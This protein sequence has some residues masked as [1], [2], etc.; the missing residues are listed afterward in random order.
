MFADAKDSGFFLFMLK[1]KVLVGM[2][3][4]IDSTVAAL[5][6]KKKGFDV[7]GIFML[8][9]NSEGLKENIC[10]SGK[11]LR[12]L[13]KVCYKY[14]IPLKV[15]DIKNKFQQT[16]VNDFIAKYEA[17]L[18]P[19]PCVLCNEKIKFS[20]LLKEAKKLNIDFISTG[21]YVTKIKCPDFIWRNFEKRS[22]YQELIFCLS[23]AKD[24]KKD[25]S[26]FLYRLSQAQ[27]QKSLFPL[28][29]YLKSEVRKIANDLKIPSAN[30]KE[31]QD[32]CFVHGNDVKKFLEA[33]A[34]KKSKG[35]KIIDASGKELGFHDGLLH[36]TIGQRKGIKIGGSGPY[37]VV[38]RDFEK[39]QMTV[40][41]DP[42]DLKLFSKKIKLSNVNW[43][44]GMKPKLPFR[45]NAQVRYKTKIVPAVVFKLGNKYILTFEKYEK[46]AAPGQS[47]VFY[48]D[49]IVIG[50][51]IIDEVCQP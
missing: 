44:M 4:G 16:I 39:N 45:I 5:L 7:I 22:S 27:V 46:I 47:A 24:K 51:G 37:F 50:G 42:N 25:Q 23:V 33:N 13:Q 48:L 49:D 12:D 28:G 3:G 14:D 26:Y 1:R 30:K 41:K 35:G 19:N 32:V 21:H 34:I 40:S 31:S 10:C 36:F 8:F 43:Q 18:T 29:N 6:L 17:G 20:A 11:A 15:L 38:S 9:G 2:S